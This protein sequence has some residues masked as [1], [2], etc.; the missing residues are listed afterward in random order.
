M[1]LCMVA[2]GGIA[3]AGDSGYLSVTGPCRLE[4]PRDHGP[5]PGFRTEWWYWTGNLKSE[6]GRRFG[7]QLT[8]FRYQLTPFGGA[9]AWPD[10]PSAWRSRQ[11]YLGHAALSDLA[12]K[13]HFQAER[14]ARQALGLGGWVRWG[15]DITLFLRNWYAVI[16]P[17]AQRLHAEGDEFGFTLEMKPTK[18]PVRHG[19]NGY[20]RKGAA[21]ERASCYYSFSRLKTTGT[22]TAGGKSFEVEGESW[23]DHEF[24]TAPLEPGTLGWDWF[25]I[26][27][28]DK[29]EIMLYLLRQEDGGLNPASSGTYI[30]AT[31]ALRHLERNYFQVRVKE[32]WKSP[33]TGA[34]YPRRW[35]LSIPLLGVDLEVSS[36]LADQEMRTSGTTG[37]SYWEGSVAV[38]GTKGGGA[39]EG[40]GYVEMTG[41]AGP[42]S[43]LK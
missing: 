13:R 21:P 36:N 7:F 27:L 25:S 20:S 42:F 14:A 2:S 23:M 9:S 28:A 35:G 43:A 17:D 22:V 11:I 18:A 26:Q 29:T 34:V 24:S 19:I 10:P 4:F 30:D 1:L 16:L 15:P 12:G 32:T 33:K 41:Y 5:H 39:V 3:A 37:V 8:F 40:H 31:G 6:T 38:K